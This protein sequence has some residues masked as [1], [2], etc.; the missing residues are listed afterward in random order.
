[1]KLG[2]IFALFTLSTIVKGAWFIAAVQ[3]VILSI[4]A[5][6]AAID[7]DVID[8]QPIKFRNF[9]AETRHKE[10]LPGFE[11]DDFEDDFKKSPKEKNDVG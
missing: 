2:S 1:M 11:I 9:F 3:P 5:I 6:L 10:D 7:L 8:I 4:G